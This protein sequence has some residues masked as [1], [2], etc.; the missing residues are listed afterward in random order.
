MS[1]VTYAIS[2]SEPQLSYHKVDQL[3]SLEGMEVVEKDDIPKRAVACS[4]CF[5]HAGIPYP[6]PYCD[7]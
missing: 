6:F 2:D 1:G 4:Q 3:H 5:S 7:T